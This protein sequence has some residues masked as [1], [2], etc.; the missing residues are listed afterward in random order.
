MKQIKLVQKNQYIKKI[1]HNKKDY[2]S[3]VE[4]TIQPIQQQAHWGGVLE[5][6]S[7]WAFAD[8][9]SYKMNLRDMKNNWDSH[10]KRAA[11]TTP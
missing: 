5:P 4:Y 9:G 7:M 11:E 10:K 2:F 1:A 3:S 8:Q 6:N